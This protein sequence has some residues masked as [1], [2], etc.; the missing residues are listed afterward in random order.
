MEEG[1]FEVEWSHI[2]CSL[3]AFTKKNSELFLLRN[4]ITLTSIQARIIFFKDIS[5]F[6]VILIWLKRLNS[7]KISDSTMTS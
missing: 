1:S 4:I 3:V 5:C 6:L 2:L 7:N